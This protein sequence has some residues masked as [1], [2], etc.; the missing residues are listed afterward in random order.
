MDFVEIQKSWTRVHWWR[1]SSMMYRLQPAGYRKK[2]HWNP[3]TPIPGRGELSFPLNCIPK[4]K[5]IH[6]SQRGCSEQLLQRL[7][8][9]FEQSY[10][11]FNS[12]C[13]FILG[14][15]LYSWYF[16]DNSHKYTRASNLL[17]LYR[18]YSFL[19][20]C[21]DILYWS[22]LTLTYSLSYFHC[23]YTTY[24]W[25]DKIFWC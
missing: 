18:T 10:Y 4:T 7:S 8:T 22:I 11:L 14:K 19:F 17:L 9:V 12:L 3:F 24:L 20:G 5:N 15:P 13:S 23:K 21:M 25:R 1:L 6:V 16:Y 2:F